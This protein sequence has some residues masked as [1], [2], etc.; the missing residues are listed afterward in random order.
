M[1]LAESL[2]LTEESLR[3]LQDTSFFTRLLP[4]VKT[5]FSSLNHFTVRGVEPLKADSKT[6]CDPGK[7]SCDLGLAVKVGGSR[8]VRE[9]TQQKNQ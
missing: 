6:T 5:S 7:T 8:F 2:G 4:P 3:E 9:S 1:Y